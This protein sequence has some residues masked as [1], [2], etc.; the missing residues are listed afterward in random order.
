MKLKHRDNLP[1]ISISSC[2][3]G[4]LGKPIINYYKLNKNVTFY[5]KNNEYY[6]NNF[7]YFERNY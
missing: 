4:H 7:P 3:L 1:I 6:R 2:V 5:I